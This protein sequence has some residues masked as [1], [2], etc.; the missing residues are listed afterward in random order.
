MG[1]AN[2]EKVMLVHGITTPTPVWSTTAPKLV[3][4]GYRVLTYDLYGRG[5]SDSPSVP[6]DVPLFMSQIAYLL[7][8]LP[9]WT[10]F[11]LI[12]MSL[13]GGIVSNFTHYFPNRVNKL[14]LICPAGATP[15]PSLRPGLRLFISNYISIGSMQGLAQILPLGLPLSSKNPLVNWQMT[16]H[17]GFFFSF[18]SSLRQ[19][20]I[21]DQTEVMRKVI[22]EKA[23]DGTV[24]AI[25]GDEDPI[26][27]MDGSL[28]HLQEQGE[29]LKAKTT[30]V[31]GGQH[32][33][34]VDR[35]EEVVAAILR[36]LRK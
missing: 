35:S 11:H 27:P 25:W 4:A 1:P 19:G 23:A 8:A 31:K 34:V 2:G 17:P 36:D 12:G 10:S 13:G 16:H 22:K 30:V 20:P 26:V 24:S 32:F 21:F 9:H 7:A 15:R 33:I 29:V 14:I 5:Y 18:L 3:E 6:H 28:R